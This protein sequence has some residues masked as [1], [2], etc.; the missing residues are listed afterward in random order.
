MKS[1]NKVFL[2]LF[3]AFIVC[4]QSIASEDRAFFWKATLGEGTVYLLGSMHFAS[5]SF[6]PLRKEI[7]QAF[8]AADALVVEVSMDEEGV[9]TYR[10]I[11][12][13]EGS[14]RGTE[15]IKDH[16]SE[17]TFSGCDKRLIAHI[18]E[19]GNGGSG[20]NTDDDNDNRKLD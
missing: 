16:I 17:N 18:P 1:V 8:A 3:C 11:V 6:Y 20:Q 10:T 7:E 12:E 13:R 2:G 15:T 14:Y 4:A 5:K 9:N 19:A